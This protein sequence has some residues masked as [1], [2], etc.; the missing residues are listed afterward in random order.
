MA[1]DNGAFYM[2]PFY[3]LVHSETTDS[4]ILTHFSKQRQVQTSLCCQKHLLAQTI[5]QILNQ[6]QT[7][8]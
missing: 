8:I 7:Y 2:I 3:V 4:L 1:C 6:H 5:F